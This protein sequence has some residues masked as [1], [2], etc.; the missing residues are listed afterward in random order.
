LKPKI[1]DSVERKVTNLIEYERGG[2]DDMK[3]DKRN[4]GFE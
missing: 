2:L 4:T 1:E 3:F